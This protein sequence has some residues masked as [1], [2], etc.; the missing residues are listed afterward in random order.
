[1]TIDHIGRI[2]YLHNFRTSSANTKNISYAIKADTE[3]DDIEERMCASG[4]KCWNDRKIFLY[5]TY[6]QYSHLLRTRI[7][8]CG[9]D[10]VSRNIVLNESAQCFPK[11]ESERDILRW[12]SLAWTK[13]DNRIRSLRLRLCIVAIGFT[14]HRGHAATL[15]PFPMEQIISVVRLSPSLSLPLR[16]YGPSTFI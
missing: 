13:R 1:M 14:S 2:S 4:L 6:S 9:F 8:G 16:L 5:L 15:S 11:R 3:C 10:L 7:L 12:P